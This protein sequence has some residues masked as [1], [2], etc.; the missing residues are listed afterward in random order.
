M[1][2]TMLR[3]PAVKSRTGLSRSSIYKFQAEGRFPQTIRLGVRSVGW[4][5]AEIDEWLNRRV[6]D[7]GTGGPKPRDADRE[8]RYPAERM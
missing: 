3:L 2:H 1:A 7:R 5:E 8:L 6:G 4:L